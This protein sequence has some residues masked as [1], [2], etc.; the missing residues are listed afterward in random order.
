MDNNTKSAARGFLLAVLIVT[1]VALMARASGAGPSKEDYANLAAIKENQKVL[2]KT[3]LAAQEFNAAKVE[4]ER[5]V[6]EL[7]ANG[8]NVDW[9]SLDLV[10][11]P[12]PEQKKESKPQASMLGKLYVWVGVEQYKNDVLKTYQAKLKERG[13]EDTKIFVAQLIQENGRLDPLFI[14]DKGCSIG[15]PQ[16]NACAKHKMSAA[17]WIKIHPEWATLEHQLNWLADDV[18]KNVEKFGSQ[19]LAVINHNCP[20]CAHARVDACYAGGKR[21]KK[22]Y[23]EA[24]SSR[25]SL[26]QAI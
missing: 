7:N 5:L 1:S 13:I 25:L 8:W 12:K 17:A 3:R 23:Y 11:A 20:K 18:Q 6:K 22:C 21:L 15:I 16:Y 24:V 2:A 4:N 14:G 26:L 10:A 9:Q 19:K